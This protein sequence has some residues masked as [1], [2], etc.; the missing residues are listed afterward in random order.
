MWVCV[1]VLAPTGLSCFVSFFLVAGGC[2]PAGVFG[3]CRLLSGLVQFTGWCCVLWF[4]WE[5]V[6]AEVFGL[7][8][9][10]LH[11]RIKA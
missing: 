8:I 6:V 2:P 4:A 3:W 11:V 7:L 5:E 9:I 10:E 1:G